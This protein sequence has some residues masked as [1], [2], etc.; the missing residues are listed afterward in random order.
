MLLLPQLIGCLVF[1]LNAAAA[2]ATKWLLHPVVA[3]FYLTITLCGFLYVAS[4]MVKVR[5]EPCQ[6][7]C[8]ATAISCFL[9]TVCLV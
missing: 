6:G 9:A 8:Y 4:L 2:V 3:T 5:K 7:H 1:A